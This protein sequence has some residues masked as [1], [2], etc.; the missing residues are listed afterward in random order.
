M[1]LGQAIDACQELT[2]NAEQGT[3]GNVQRD[4]IPR[5]AGNTLLRFRS[6]NLIAQALKLDRNHHWTKISLL[7]VEP[8]LW[9]STST[10]AKD[11]FRFLHFILAHPQCSRLG[12]LDDI[13]CIA[14][15]SR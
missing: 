4:C 8:M 12:V 7:L 11:A 13:V 6:C 2:D 9:K 3:F 10:H 15:D 1:N 5:Q 14:W